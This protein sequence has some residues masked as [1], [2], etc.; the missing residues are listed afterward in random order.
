[1]RAAAPASRFDD[2]HRVAEDLAQ[3]AARGETELTQVVA[4]APRRRPCAVVQAVGAR[5]LAQLPERR[6]L[7]DQQREVGDAEILDGE[8]R[9]LGAVRFVEAD[10]VAGVVEVR[11]GGH[12]RGQCVE[13]VLRD[14][15]AEVAPSRKRRMRLS[16]FRSAVVVA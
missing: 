2:A 9:H 5:S 8:Q 10:E 14:A 13:L 16:S 4:H 12:R 3:A 11:A 1:M 6:A 7:V 15:V